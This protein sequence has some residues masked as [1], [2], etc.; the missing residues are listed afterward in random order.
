MNHPGPIVQKQVRFVAVLATVMAVAWGADEVRAQPVPYN[1]Y[2]EAHDPL[3]PV[4]AD[5]TLRW[6]TFY[7]SASIQ[8]SYE[9]LWNMGACRGT[10][11]AITVPVERNK[12]LIDN[13]PEESFSGRVRAAT[14]TI[15]GGMVAFT[16]GAD[17]DPTAAV[18]V[19]QLHPAGVSHVRVGGKTS[20]AALEPGMSVRLRAQVDD[21]GRALEPVRAIDI[22]TPPADFKPD[23]VRSHTLDTIV[24]TVVRSRNNLLL[25]KID[26]GTIRRVSVPLADAV[27]VMIVDAA[28]LALIAPGDEI[29]ITGRRWSGAGAMGSGTVF[30]SHIIVNKPAAQPATHDLGAVE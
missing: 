21:K 20:I 17:V 2:A 9:R 13:L 11:K 30:A 1:P 29:E 7:K 22:V 27:E 19:A 16:E 26:A 15:A 23:P 12:L 14:G 6:G 10:N 3:P 8:K 24:G 5:G 28:E 4:A 18:L 25:L